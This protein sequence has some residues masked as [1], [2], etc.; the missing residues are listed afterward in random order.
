MRICDKCKEKATNKVIFAVEDQRF[1][2]CSKCEKE[3]LDLLIS[4]PKKSKH[5]L[6]S[7]KNK[8]S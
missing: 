8:A 3:V 1:D 5:S 6:L 2:V 7:L 4:D